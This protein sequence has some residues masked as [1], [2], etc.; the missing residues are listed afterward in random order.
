M[1]TTGGA[2]PEVVGKDGE[3]GLL[4]PPDRPAQLTAAFAGEIDAKTA[5]DR[6]AASVDAVMK[7]AGYH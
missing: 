4:V 6:A 7:D 5:L 1:A 2:L 3:T